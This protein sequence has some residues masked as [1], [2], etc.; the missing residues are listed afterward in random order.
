MRSIPRSILGA[1]LLAAL[2]ATSARGEKTFQDVT[3]VVVVE[4][5]VQ[6]TRDGRPVRGLTAADFEV[7]DGRK[8]RPIVGFDVIDVAPGAP[9]P[10]RTAD[11][12][13]SGRRHFLLLFDLALSR[14]YSIVKARRAT[15]ELVETSLHPSDRVAVGIYSGGSARLLLNFTSDREQILTAIQ[16]LGLPQLVDRV[17]I[18]S[19]SC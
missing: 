5:P 1:A 4:I 13:V 3:D 12:P 2:L 17:P 7:R 9:V 10:T 11:I 16:T 6:V 14:P 18:L 8:R 19:A 15:V